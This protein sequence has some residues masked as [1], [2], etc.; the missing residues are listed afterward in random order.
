MA[1]DPDKYLAEKGLGFDPDAYLSAKAQQ[2]DPSIMQKIGSFGKEALGAIAEPLLKMG[3]GMLAKP[4]SDVAGLA[5]I[6]AHA[7]GIIQTSPTDIQQSIQQGMTYQPRTEA[8]ASGA[9]PLNAIPE[10]LNAA[11]EHIR[12][13]A[14]TD[15]SS[16]GGMAQNALREAIPQALG[17]AGMKYGPAIGGAL[18]K[19][20]G[21]IASEVAGVTTGAGG[22]SLKL[23]YLAGK[24]KDPV[25][26]SN[27]RGEVP[28][29]QV[30]QEAKD[31]LHTMQDSMADS[32]RT[33][34]SGWA[35]DQTPLDFK[36]IDQAFNKL[37]SS[38]KQNGHSLVGKAEQAKIQEVRET[39]DEWRDDPSSHTTLGLDAL[40]RRID[41]IYPEGFTQKQAQRVITGTRNAVKDTIVKQAPEYAKA[42]ADYEKQMG[43]IRDI[44][45]S[46]SL[47]DKV[48]KDTAIRKLQSLM[49][50]NVQTGYGQRMALAD[51][52]ESEGGVNLRPALAG[53]ALNQV[54][55]R[56]LARISASLATLPLLPAYSPRLMG[57]TFYGAGRMAD[58]L[59]PLPGLFGI[60][61]D[62]LSAQLANQPE[63]K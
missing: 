31:G 40:K 18:K 41:A 11:V 29:E 6:P 43:V 46:L 12:P 3:S 62:A 24:N 23:A 2:A 35:A 13:T 25:F 17:I 58:N 53:Q 33:A 8:G 36:P 27:M 44:E 57:E 52:L 28:V 63:N 45:K 37:E 16:Y 32:Y 5:A 42:M 21:T 22:E 7:A 39:L 49:R 19:G 59:G 4:V 14:S 54:A 15:P 30:L 55:P 10:A 47:G 26:I 34:K 9:N 61:N 51:T 20:A 1:F 48:A 50:N 56:G 60:G 38:L